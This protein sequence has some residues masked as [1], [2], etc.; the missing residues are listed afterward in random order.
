MVIELRY[1]VEPRNTPA[2]CGS[3]NDGTSRLVGVALTLVLRQECEAEIRTVKK[4]ALDQ[5]TGSKRYAVFF[6]LHEVHAISKEAIPAS[7]AVVDVTHRIGRRADSAISN[8]L[9]K[10]GLVEKSMKEC[11][12]SQPHLS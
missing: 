1:R 7:D 4:I 12:V 2:A 9:K 8:V 11:R 10:R 5:T 6:P 3:R